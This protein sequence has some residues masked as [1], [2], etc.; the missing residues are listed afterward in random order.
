MGRMERRSMRAQVKRQI[1]V[2]GVAVTADSLRLAEQDW[3]V[4]Y[5]VGLTR[6]EGHPE[7]VVV[8]ECDD[9]AERMLRGAADVVRRGTRLAPGWGLTLEGWLH[10]LI[11]VEHPDGNQSLYAHLNERSVK[12][13]DVI[14]TAD[15]LGKVGE[16][17]TAT[18]PHLH[19]E[20]HQEGR[21]IDPLSVI[22]AST[23]AVR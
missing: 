15:S 23:I 10:V 14:T 12:V 7:I 6:L 16:T 9:C 17:G 2:Q 22:P 19:L 21:P 11:E 13:G 8:G 18:G 5:T 4:H 20:I 1:A 3:P